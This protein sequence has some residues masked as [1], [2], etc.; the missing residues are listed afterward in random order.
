[1]IIRIDASCA[2]YHNSVLFRISGAQSVK[3]SVYSMGQNTFCLHPHCIKAIFKQVL[4]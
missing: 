3:K 2:K 1:M 4:K